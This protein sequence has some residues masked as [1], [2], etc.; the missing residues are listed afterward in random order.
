MGRDHESDFDSEAEA[1]L[2]DERVILIIALKKSSIICNKK[3]RSSF[4]E[5]HEI[6]I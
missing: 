5:Y 6:L 1:Y 3:S 4:S 2:G